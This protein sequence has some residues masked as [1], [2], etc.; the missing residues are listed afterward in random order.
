MASHL[1]HNPRWRE[2]EA[3]PESELSMD[4]IEHIAALMPDIFDP[5]TWK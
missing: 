2:V 1:Y 5:E 3:D 4:E